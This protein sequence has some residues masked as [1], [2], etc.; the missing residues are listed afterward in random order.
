MIN[1]FISDLHLEESRPDIT[2]IFLKF[3]G[4]ASRSASELYILGDFFEVWIGDDDLTAFNLKIMKALRTAADAGLKIYF[5]HGNRDFLIGKKFL[6]MTRCALLPDEYVLKI[7]DRPILLMHGDTLCT[8]D[9][10]YVKFRKKSHN[11]LMQKFFLMKKLSTR[12]LIAANMRAKSKIHTSTVPDYLMD[13][14][15]SEVEQVMRKHKVK[16]MIHGHTHRPES[17]HFEIDGQA[18]MRLVLAPWH[19]RGCVLIYDEQGNNKIEILES[20]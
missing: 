2:A 9:L 16:H 5:M 4:D 15:Q 7:A 12:Q 6:R 17:H 1:Y 11:W 8:A 19:D 3:L 20:V 13:V 18:V 10:N 14:T